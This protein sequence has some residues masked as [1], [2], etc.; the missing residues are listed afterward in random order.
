MT[1]KISIILHKSS[2]VLRIR[3][4]STCGLA[5]WKLNSFRCEG[6]RTHSCRLSGRHI[7]LLTVSLIYESDSVDR[8]GVCRTPQQPSTFDQWL[9]TYLFEQ[10][11]TQS[12]AVVSLL[13][14][15]CRLKPW[16]TSLG[17]NYMR[18]IHASSQIS[19]VSRSFIG[20]D[21]FHRWLHLCD[22]TAVINRDWHSA[23]LLL[24]LPRLSDIFPNNSSPWLRQFKRKTHDANDFEHHH[25]HQQQQQCRILL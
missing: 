19:R 16:V 11:A 8:S 1:S 17:N 9:K 21:T 2:F 18:L 7:F 5:I 22:V 13:R 25:H 24:L 14:F 20:A 4:T 3:P 12:Y 23:A 10:W 15:W 6:R